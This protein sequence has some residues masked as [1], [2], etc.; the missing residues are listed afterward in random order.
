MQI[1]GD[2]RAD[3]QLIA[4]TRGSKQSEALHSEAAVV[5]AGLVCLVCHGDVQMEL[6]QRPGVGLS[7]TLPSRSDEGFRVEESLKESR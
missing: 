6:L 3:G 7:D 2:L 5:E 4:P 1:G